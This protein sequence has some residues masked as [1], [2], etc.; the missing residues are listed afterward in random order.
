LQVSRSDGAYLGVFAS[1]RRRTRTPVRV[2]ASL[3]NQVAF[4]AGSD[5]HAFGGRGFIPPITL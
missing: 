3:T 2:E 1:Q 5:Y 4:R